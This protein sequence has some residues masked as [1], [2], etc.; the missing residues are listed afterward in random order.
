MKWPIQTLHSQAL[1]GKCSGALCG[2]KSSNTVLSCQ[3]KHKSLLKACSPQLS[4]WSVSTL[5]IRTERA[6][7]WSRQLSPVCI[8]LG[9][10]TTNVT[11]WC[12]NSLSG[13]MSPVKPSDRSP[14]PRR[15]Q[16]G[17]SC[18]KYHASNSRCWQKCSRPPHPHKMLCFWVSFSKAA[19]FLGFVCLQP[20]S[21]KNVQRFLA[22]S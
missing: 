16:G 21:G 8:S 18:V 5:R 10:N 1:R 9:G 2:C 20:I 14:V 17:L 6:S 4:I 11:F 15:M 13:V 7:P 12:L 22:L 19:V 3:I